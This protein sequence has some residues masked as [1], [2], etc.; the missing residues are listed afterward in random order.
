MI[1][2]SRA[3]ASWSS[4]GV[5]TST[6]RSRLRSIRSAE[7]MYHS[8]PAAVAEHPDPRVLEELADDRP[9]ADVL[10]DARH[11]RHEA[12]GA[13]DDAGRPATPA[14]EAS[15]SASMHRRVHEEL[16]LI[17][18]R[19]RRAGAGVAPPR[20]RPARGTG[21]RSVIGATSSRRNAR[22]RD[23]PVSTLNRSVTSAPSSSRQVRSPRSVYRRAVFGVVVAGADVDVAAQAD[24]LA[25]H[26]ERDLGVGL[27]PDE[28]VDDVGARLLE[29]AGPRRCCSPRRSG[30]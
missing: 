16:I 6:R 2:A 9:D 19:R 15:Y 26:D 28:A 29:R 4:T 21:T 3:C 18:I 25:A 14:R 12:A 22:W 11:A 24:A 30:P 17:T 7:P 10:R 1:R 5:T 13:A 23:R 27:E 8:R 20:A